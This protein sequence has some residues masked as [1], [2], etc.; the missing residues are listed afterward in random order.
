MKRVKS[1]IISSIFHLS[2]LLYLLIS[3]VFS[4]NHHHDKQEDD[5]YSEINNINQNL[6][7]IKNDYLS[8]LNLDTIKINF[9]QVFG[10]VKVRFLIIGY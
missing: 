7:K 9:K 4:G 1:I 2:I 8:H 10:D 6:L 5:E 3:L